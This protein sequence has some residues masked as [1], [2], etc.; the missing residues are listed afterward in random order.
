MPLRK[1]RERHEAGIGEVA[2]VRRN[3]YS[4]AAKAA[5]QGEVKRRPWENCLIERQAKVRRLYLAQAELLIASP[6][7]ADKVLGRKV[8][9]FVRSMPQPDTQRLALAREFRLANEVFLKHIE[10][11]TGRSVGYMSK[12]DQER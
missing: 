2:R 11:L 8:E 12:H 9:A 5:F 6:H 10:E 1:I 3:A 4:E 7:E